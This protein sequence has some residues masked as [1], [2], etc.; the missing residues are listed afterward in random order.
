[1]VQLLVHSLFQGLILLPTVK[2]VAALALDDLN[3]GGQALEVSKHWLGRQQGVLAPH[4]TYK[5]S[6]ILLLSRGLGE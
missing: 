2:T 3:H 6:S 4:H 1:V 5:G